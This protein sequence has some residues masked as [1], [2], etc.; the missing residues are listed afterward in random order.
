MK[1]EK[2]NDK[3]KVTYDKLTNREENVVAI[4]ETMKT[5]ISAAGQSTVQKAKDLTEIT[6]LHSAIS[7]AEEQ[8]RELYTNLGYEIY[9]AY[10]EKPLPEVEDQIRQI[11][12]LHQ[13][14]EDCKA[15]GFSGIHI[16]SDKVFDMMDIYIKEKG[17]PVDEKVGT[18][19]RIMNF[20]MWASSRQPIYGV[21]AENLDFLD[22]G[23]LDTLELAEK[24]LKRI[25]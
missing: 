12:E 18:R 11:T 15:L 8:I 17:L 4:F 13:K 9:R 20:Y 7:G 1:K 5:K 21:V 3:I 23:K 22:V 2:N 14:I 10:Y 24:D 19:F 6:K 16:M 25:V